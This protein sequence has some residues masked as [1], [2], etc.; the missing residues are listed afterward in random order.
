MI[1]WICR[2]RHNTNPVYQVQ[3]MY[4]Q[5][6]SRQISQSDCSIHIKSNY[7]SNIQYMYIIVSNDNLLYT[8][9]KPN[10]NYKR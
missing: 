1:I 4:N 5:Y 7:L 8:M 2:R 9:Y 10:Q 6:Y 3:N